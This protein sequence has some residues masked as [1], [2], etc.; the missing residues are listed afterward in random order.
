MT[1]MPHHIILDG[2][3][4]IQACIQSK[5][6]PIHTVYI[7]TQ[8]QSRKIDCF[9]NVLE[10]NSIHVQCVPPDF[11]KQ[12]SAG[13]TNGGIVATAGKRVFQSAETIFDS[14]AT[15]HFYVLLEGIE[16]PFNVGYCIRSL[17][18]LGVNGLFL[19]ARD[20]GAAESIIVRASAGA[21][22]YMPICLYNDAAELA[23][24]ARFRNI[25]IVCADA[26]DKAIDLYETQFSAPMLLVIGGEKRGIAMDFL[27]TAS[28]VVKIP[29]AREFRYSLPAASATSILA[30]EVM[31]QLRQRDAVREV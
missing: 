11:I 8:K 15:P 4:S 12:L 18:A 27:S 2:I 24:T 10:E 29:Y 22:E 26:T 30:Y 14:M 25:D 16:D 19:S 1:T 21:S 20:W 3:I 13:K 6:R 28:T 5:S 23:S 9:L 17:Y 7:G 31:R